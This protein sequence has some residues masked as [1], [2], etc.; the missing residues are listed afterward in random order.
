MTIKY[1]KKFDVCPNCGSM[2]RVIETETREEASKEGGAI[3]IDTKTGCLMTQTGI[4]DP[5]R[6]G[7][8][9]PK[10][11]PVIMARYDICADCGTVY[12]VE[13]QKS[14]ATASPQTRRDDFRHH[15]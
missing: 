4:Y 2:V 9:A 14:E 3:G 13:V 1:P 6:T 15:P 7:I 12:C 11:I 10:K 5:T 8:I